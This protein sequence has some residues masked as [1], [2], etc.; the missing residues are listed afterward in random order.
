MRAILCIILALAWLPA[1][2]QSDPREA[3]LAALGELGVANGTALACRQSD[4]AGRIKRLVIALAPRTRAWGERFEQ[5]TNDGFLA[6]HQGGATCPDAATVA[7]DVDR[8]EARL[9]ALLGAS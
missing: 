2:A 8:L 4:N 5:A 3:G 9:R 6:Q 1:Q 7:A